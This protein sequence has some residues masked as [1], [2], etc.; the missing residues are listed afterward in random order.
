METTK[1]IICTFLI[2]ILFVHFFFFFL[3]LININFFLIIIDALIFFRKVY[4]FNFIFIIVIFFMLIYHFSDRDKTLSH[5]THW[6]DLIDL[7]PFQRKFILFKNISRKQLE[8]INF[9]NVC[10][11]ICKWLWDQNFI[12]DNKMQSNLMEYTYSMS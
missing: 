6:S 12:R 2:I 8:F 11:S 9:I 4:T 1:T 7:Y 3:L 10:V 5:L